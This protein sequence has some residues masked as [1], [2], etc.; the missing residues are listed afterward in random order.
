[1]T[2]TDDDGLLLLLFFKDKCF[3]RNPGPANHV[4]LITPVSV[5]AQGAEPGSLS[6]L[7]WM[8]SL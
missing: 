5:G 7:F 2:T 8:S 1:M 4:G 3:A 6:L